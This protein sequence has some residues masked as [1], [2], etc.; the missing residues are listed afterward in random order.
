MVDNLTFGVLT[1]PD[2]SYKKVSGYSLCEILTYCTVVFI[3]L[4]VG[5][6]KLKNHSIY[7]VSPKAIPYTQVVLEDLVRHIV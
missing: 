7:M 1:R 3:W 6:Q 2:G 4:G 5:F